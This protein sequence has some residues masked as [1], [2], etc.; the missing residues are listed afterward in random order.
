M[1]NF[2]G[3]TAIRP[4]TS[5]DEPC[6][7]DIRGWRYD[8]T[9]TDYALTTTTTFFREIYKH[10]IQRHVVIC[11][12][13][14]LLLYTYGLVFLVFRPKQTTVW[15]A[16]LLFNPEF[17]ICTYQELPNSWYVHIRNL[18]RDMYISQFSNSWYVHIMNSGLNSKTAFHTT[19]MTMMITFNYMLLAFYSE[20]SIA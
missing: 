15:N 16:V 11:G 17:M 20:D 10:C 1:T 6:H 19:V 7:V 9:L 5:E 18:I 3:T 14:A 2:V 12:W 4:L 8:W 13:L